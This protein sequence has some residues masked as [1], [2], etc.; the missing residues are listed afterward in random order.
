MV[1]SVKQAE[2]Y[3][4]LKIISIILIVTRYSK[5]EREREKGWGRKRKAGRRKRRSV[6]TEKRHSVL[7]TVRSSKAAGVN[8]EFVNC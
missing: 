4:T 1:G 7:L 6:E 8:A 3:E 5:R 2:L